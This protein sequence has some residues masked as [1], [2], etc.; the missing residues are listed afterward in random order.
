MFYSKAQ[1]SLTTPIIDRSSDRCEGAD[2]VQR[3][4]V[5]EDSFTIRK[6]KTETPADLISIGTYDAELMAFIAVENNKSIII[7]GG[8]ASGKTSTMNAA[9]LFIP[10]IAKIVSIEDTREIQLPHDN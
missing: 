8:T 9:S 1:L 7:V 5:E 4:R 10:P 2:Y 3:Y 6:F